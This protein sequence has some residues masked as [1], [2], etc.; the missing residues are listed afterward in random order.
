MT[1]HSL[2][3]LSHTE[4]LRL[5]P[6]GKHSGM[7]ITLQNVNESGYIYI[8]GEGVTSTNYGYRILPNSAISFEL[9]G[10]YAIYAIASESNI[11]LAKFVIGLETQN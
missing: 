4:A 8:G 11:K 5:T 6:L 2:I 9:P 7:D 1:E 3:N 10:G